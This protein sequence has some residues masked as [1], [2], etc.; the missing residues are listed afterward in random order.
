MLHLKIYMCYIWKYISVTFVPGFSFC[1]ICFTCFCKCE[2]WR[3]G[4]VQVGTKNMKCQDYSVVCHNFRL[5]CC[6]PQCIAIFSSAEVSEWA[7]TAERYGLETYH[8]YSCGGK[9][10]CL[11]SRWER[12]RLIVLL[13]LMLIQDKLHWYCFSSKQWL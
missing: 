4:K 5:F 13:M 8:S 11:V 12:I 1:A 3:K 7:T 10:S 6:L 2:T 9:C